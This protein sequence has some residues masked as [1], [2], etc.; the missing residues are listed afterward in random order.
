MQ[1]KSRKKIQQNERQRDDYFKYK[2]VAARIDMLNDVW[3]D[4]IALLIV[5]ANL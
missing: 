1:H 2:A 5:Y 4:V 3:N